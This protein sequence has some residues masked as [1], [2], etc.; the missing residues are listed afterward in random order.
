M[1]RMSSDPSNLGPDDILKIATGIERILP[2]TYSDRQVRN[3]VM[4]PDFGVIYVLRIFG[5]VVCSA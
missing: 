2:F 5:S 4:D 1:L 3:N